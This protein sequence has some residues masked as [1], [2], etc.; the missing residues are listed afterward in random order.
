[1]LRNLTIASIYFSSISCSSYIQATALSHS[2]TF[3]LDRSS[4][5]RF[6]N[7]FYSSS[8]GSVS[9]QFSRSTMSH[10]LNSAIRIDSL[11]LFRYEIHNTHSN[12]SPEDN[13]SVNEMRFFDCNAEFDGG[14]IFVILDT[15]FVCN[16]TVF[17][18]C[19]AQS[20]GGAIFCIVPQVNFTQGCFSHCQSKLGTAIYAPDSESNFT[21]EGCYSDYSIKAGSQSEYVFYASSPDIIATTSNFSH[22]SMSGNGVLFLQTTHLFALTHFTFYNNTSEDSICTL[23]QVQSVAGINN[24]NFI[25]NKAKSIIKINLFEPILKNIYFSQSSI[26]TSYFNLTS[27]TKL[28]LIDCHFDLDQSKIPSGV[29]AN[30]CTFSSESTM[31]LDHVITKG[32]WDHSTY[33]WSPPKLA[34]QIIVGI[35][36]AAILIGAFAAAAIHFYCRNKKKKDTQQLIPEISNYENSD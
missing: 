3:K 12:Y 23:S 31:N 1:M 5:S 33:T 6:I 11:Q 19:S 22:N 30:G 14:A 26:E 15:F 4:V 13:L 24:T 8:I 21:F 35:I 16:F 28:T 20:K 7:P 29:T 25:G 10:F 27:E 34:Y 2:S 9:A 32:C 17:S 18:N 36:I